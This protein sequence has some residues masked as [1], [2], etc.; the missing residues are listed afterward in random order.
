MLHTPPPLRQRTV[1]FDIS[2]ADMD[3]KLEHFK[4]QVVAEFVRVHGDIKSIQDETLNSV[5]GDAFHDNAMQVEQK[6]TRA[7]ALMAA[8]GASTQ[9]VAERLTTVE[10]SDV[11]S[12]HL[13]DKAAAN[14][15]TLMDKLK[16]LEDELQR[17]TA[18]S[19]EQAAMLAA[20]QETADAAFARSM[21]V[22]AAGDEDLKATVELQINLLK[23]EVATLKMS[24]TQAAIIA[25]SSRVSDVAAAAAASGMPPLTGWAHGPFGAGNGLGD[26]PTRMP[27]G[28]TGSMPPGMV[29]LSPCHCRH[30]DQLKD[31]ID[32]AE[33]RL[34][35]A[36]KFCELPQT[37]VGAIHGSRERFM[38]DGVF[39][40]PAQLP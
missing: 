10:L 35:E 2:G 20:M 13:L 23:S 5:T 39:T 18:A 6:M 27:P 8:L 31:R 12:R 17:W 36:D 40:P 37:R 28:M 29:G 14:E 19:A 22:V 38:K 7:D 11:N 32:A 3:A 33:A 21:T 24:A 30:L 25:G 34:A 1:A 16:V 4:Q 15:V 9:E 26:A